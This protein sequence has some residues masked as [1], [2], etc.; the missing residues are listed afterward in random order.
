MVT[1]DTKTRCPSCGETYLVSRG[2][3][4]TN[5]HVTSSEPTGLVAELR[6]TNRALLAQLDAV[7]AELQAANEDADRLCRAIDDMSG[8]LDSINDASWA[9]LSEAQTAHEARK[10]DKP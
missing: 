3:F 1:G 4:C 9:R 7:R 5:P 10:G 8:D 2:H 6:Q